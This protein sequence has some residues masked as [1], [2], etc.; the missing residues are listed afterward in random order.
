MVCGI[1]VKLIVLNLFKRGLKGWIWNII[2][3]N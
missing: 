2:N 1:F 3:F